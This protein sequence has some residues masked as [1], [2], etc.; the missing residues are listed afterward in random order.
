MWVSKINN[1]FIGKAE[2]SDIVI[3]M[4]NLLKYSDNYSMASESWWWI[5]YR[6]EVI[7]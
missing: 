2:D 3:P 5:Y 6:H 4:H 1:I 7:L